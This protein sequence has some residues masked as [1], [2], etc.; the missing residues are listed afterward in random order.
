MPR[1]DRHRWLPTALAPCAVGTK[2]TTADPGR[3]GPSRVGTRD[4]PLSLVPPHA[5][6]RAERKVSL[7]LLRGGASRHREVELAARTLRG[8]LSRS[9]GG[10][11][12]P[13]SD[14]G[15]PGRQRLPF[16]GLRPALT[17]LPQ[18]ARSRSLILGREVSVGSARVQKEA[19]RRRRTGAC[20][21]Q[22]D[23]ERSQTGDYGTARPRLGE[24]ESAGQ[25]LRGGL[26]NTA[27][28]GPGESRIPPRAPP[29]LGEVA[30]Q[31]ASA[32][33]ETRQ[34]APRHAA[35]EDFDNGLGMQRLAVRSHGPRIESM[36]DRHGD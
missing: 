15:R 1:P 8:W 5:P 24:R 10:L 19:R 11:R 16:G 32:C 23:H 34:P 31:S 3:I 26:R 35:F 20:W 33:V 2:A 12:S 30:G 9:P 14:L 29:V 27:K 18:S 17:A 7:D 21:P 25:S 28:I 22:A 6:D 13:L 4:V 36:G